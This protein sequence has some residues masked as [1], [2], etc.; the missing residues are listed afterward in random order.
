MGIRGVFPM[1][2][3]DM[4]QQTMNKIPVGDRRK[5][6]RH[7]CQEGSKSAAVLVGTLLWHNIPNQLNDRHA[8]MASV[9]RPRLSAREQS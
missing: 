5:S 7:V 8:F 2:C 3:K 6:P 4:V 9:R 1:H